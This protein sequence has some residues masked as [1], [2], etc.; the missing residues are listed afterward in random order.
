MRQR[1][2]LAATMA[3]LEPQSNRVERLDQH[4]FL[5]P[6]RPDQLDQARA[7]EA[8]SENSVAVRKLLLPSR[9]IEPKQRIYDACEIRERDGRTEILL[10]ASGD[11]S[12][13]GTRA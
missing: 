10:Q 3:I 2:P 7:G 13:S 11:I 5:M 1:I 8:L 12:E 9:R 6:I 4:P